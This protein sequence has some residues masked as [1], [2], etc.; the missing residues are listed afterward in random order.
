MPNGDPVAAVN[1]RCL[2]GIELASIPLKH[3]D[4]RS[5]PIDG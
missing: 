3:H 1:V 2:D 4:G 5:I